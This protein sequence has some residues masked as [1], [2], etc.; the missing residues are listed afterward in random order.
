MLTEELI[1]LLMRECPC[2]RGAAISALILMGR[3]K[4]QRA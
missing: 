4:P 2:T 1:E 3:M